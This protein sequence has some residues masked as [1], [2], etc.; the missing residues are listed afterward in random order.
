ML[1]NHVQYEFDP[2]WSLRGKNHPLDQANTCPNA[3]EDK[4]NIFTN[5]KLNLSW[6]HVQAL[7]QNNISY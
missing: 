6:F 4:S 1:K 2:E 3:M 7:L 5:K